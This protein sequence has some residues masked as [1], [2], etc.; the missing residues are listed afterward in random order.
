MRLILKGMIIVAIAVS[1]LPGACAQ[2]TERETVGRDAE[3]YRLESGDS[4]EIRFFY[5]PELNERVQIRPDGRISM[6]LIGEIPVAG[7]TIGD[8]T[9]QLVERYQKIIKQPSVS[10]QVTGYAN[11]KIFVGGEVER[12]GVLALGGRMTLLSAIL[13]AGGLKKSA[14]NGEALLI[15]RGPDGKPVS[16][17]I[18]LKRS[19]QSGSEAS[20]L[21]LEPFDVVLIPESGIAKANRAMDRYVRQM[22]PITLSGGFTYLFGDGSFVGRR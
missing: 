2:F 20:E 4:L 11:R 9:R 8:L 10:I 21:L 16:R 17:V 12:A 14:K 6:G 13:E 15:R 5:N 3:P 18:G 22:L 1:K 7:L 19:L